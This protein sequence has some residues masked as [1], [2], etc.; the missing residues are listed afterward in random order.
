MK[1]L[2]NIIFTEVL[3]THH[4][5]KKKYIFYGIVEFKMGEEKG[6]VLLIIRG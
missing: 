6:I 4:F 3:S 1:F 2:F 5:N